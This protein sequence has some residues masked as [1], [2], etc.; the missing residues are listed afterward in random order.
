MKI[1]TKGRYGLRAMV[2]LG[3]AFEDQ[4]YISLKS[5]SQ[6]QNIP[7][8]YL[9]RLLAKMRKADL[10]AT[11]R[12]TQGGYRLTKS[13]KEISVL[14]ILQAVDESLYLVECTEDTTSCPQYESCPSHRIWA[15]MAKQMQLVAQ[16]T[17][18]EEL[19]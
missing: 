9:E 12:G 17:N 8:N 19:L 11:R 6:N 4:E 5:V 13:P 15:K 3:R 14:E 18:L 1:T 2:E 16:E 7:E 10:V